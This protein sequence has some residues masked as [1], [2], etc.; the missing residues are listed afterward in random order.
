[1][2]RHY[3]PAGNNTVLYTRLSTG[4]N[5]TYYV[6]KD[7]LGS[8]SAITDSTGALVVNESF[9]AWGLRRGSNWQQD[10]LTSADQT[11]IDN[12]TRHGFTG[13]EMLDNLSLIDMNGRITAPGFAGRFL[14]PD[15]NIP[16]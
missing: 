6:S 5:P 16:D 13:H 4:S 11:T 8:S 14:S 12:T 15:P 10:G 3:I 9:A 1:A 7:P 2:Y